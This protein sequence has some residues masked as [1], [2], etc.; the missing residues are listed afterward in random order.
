MLNALAVNLIALLSIDI[1]FLVQKPGETAPQP[2]P[3]VAPMPP[4]PMFPKAPQTDA[5]RIINARDSI[6]Q[7]TGAIEKIQTRLKD[8]EGE[9]A[10][11]EADFEALNAKLKNAKAM[12][13]TLKKDGKTDAAMTIE[14]MLPGIQADWQLA[15]ERFDIAIRQRQ[16]SL[17]VI[18]NL[19][20]RIASDQQLLDRLNGKAA[21]TPTV[22]TPTAPTSVPPTVK[23]TPAVAVTESVAPAAFPTTPQKEPTHV[24]QA[25]VP[26][27]NHEL[28]P[29]GTPGIPSSPTATTG[30]NYASTPQTVAPV[31]LSNDLLVRN[32]Q[33]EVETRKGELREAEAR[34]RIAEERVRGMQ[35]S[36]QSAIKMLELE[37]ESVAQSEKSIAQTTNTL[38]AQPP[39]NTVEHDDQ[40]RRLNDAQ[41]RLTESKDRIARIETRIATLN[42]TL[43]GLKAELGVMAKEVEAR[44]RNLAESDSELNDLLNPT[45]PRNL[46]KWIIEKGPRLLLI[47]LGMAVVHFT[48]R[49][50]SRQIVRFIT[51]NSARGSTED[52]ENRAHTLVGVFR[53]AASIVVFGGGLVMLLDEVGLP[54]VPLM[55]GAAV[56]GLAVAFGAQNLIRDYFTGFMMLMEDQYSVNDVVR[57]GAIA[58]LVEQISLRMTVL[59]DLEGVRHFVPHGT[60]TSVSNLTHGWSRALFD[61]PVAYKENVDRV[62]DVLM[63]LGQEIRNDPVLGRHILDNP[64]MLGVDSLDDSGVTIKFLL[65]TRPLQQWPVKREMLRRIK[66]RFDELGIEIPFPHQTVYHHFPDPAGEADAQVL[67]RNKF[68]RAAV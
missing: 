54:I 15:K 16:V 45:A 19:K 12:V 5:E 24:P 31:E 48:V 8:P 43:A 42:E 33:M 40:V 35:R 13:A 44:Q 50:F 62:I 66:N 20:E 29:T 34:M 56:I 47:L 10:K 58:G 51:R 6:K 68:M 2:A 17:H 59:R 7:A 22:A 30:S 52:R 21:P 26:K 1:L 60:I 9:Y 28:N 57:I 67:L 65:K 46:L 3:A 39:A 49:Q 61:I 23:T 53:Y 18:E 27:P 63:Q 55:G 14:G 4:M 64:E 38:K 11:S 36:V 37:R 41:N 25:F 32:K